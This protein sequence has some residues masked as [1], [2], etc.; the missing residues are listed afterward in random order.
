M[1]PDV[2][3]KLREKLQNA[4][5]NPG[6]YLFRN[7]NDDI[8][9]IGKAK[10][11]KNRVR[12]YFQK[13]R[14][15][16]TKT[17]ILIRKISDLE[18]I[19]TD[20]EK[21]ALILEA[22]LI[23]LYRPRYNIS[24]KDDKSFPYIRITAEDF[25]QVYVTRRKFNDKSTYFGPYTQVK[26]MRSLLW[27][28]KKIFPI[29]SCRYS[30][31]PKAVVDK[32]YKICLDYHIKKCG[33]PCEGLVSREEYNEM[34]DQIR[35]FLRGHTRSLIEI[36]NIRMSESAE[37]RLF[38]AA[39]VFRDRLRE[40][41]NFQSR[42]KVVDIKPV[43]RDIV[44]VAV[45]D[46]VACGVL[47]Q[48]REGKIIGRRHH[49]LTGV[50]DS[51]EGEILQNFIMQVYVNEEYTPPEIFLSHSVKEKTSI[52]EWLTEKRGTGVKLIVPQKGDKAKL[53]NMCLQNAGLMLEEM[54]LQ[55]RKQK[56]FVA[57]SVQNLQK[58][59]SLQETPMIIEAFDIS[60]VQGT[61]SV[62]SMVSFCNGSPQKKEYR[63][64]KIKSKDTPDDYAM[65][66]EAVQ[67]RYS[68]LLA[69]EANMPDLILIDGG[70]GQLS[71]AVGELD[72]L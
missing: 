6:V 62:A 51:S 58:D 19:L 35:D 32:K 18:F 11:L 24:L 29:R 42:Q 69:E 14:P 48:E 56:D 10:I 15:A 25:P 2:S 66:A 22:N 40:I 30:L 33:G 61:D 34:V 38:E 31:T 53:V 13:S 20:T 64:F 55:Q 17:T 21:E 52:E 27:T 9:Y 49:G 41:N 54:L 12:S 57:Y 8:I 3:D 46:D 5:S 4:P 45:D 60:N 37:K 70:K 16:D 7:K 50:A 71:T 65:I 68:R 44:A 59:L 1:K 72:K 43:D 67:R 28:L 39:A 63:V 23:K 36:L 26:V 47:F